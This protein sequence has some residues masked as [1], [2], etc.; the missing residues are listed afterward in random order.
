MKPSELT[1]EIFKKLV[2]KDLCDSLKYDEEKAS[3][4]MEEN[5]DVI[6][7]GFRSA[8]DEKYFCNTHKMNEEDLA[9]FKRGD[10]IN[11]AISNT[12]YCLFMLE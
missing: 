10:Y 12:S 8:T 3:R 7:D 1:F 5:L 4:L 9:R 11:N 2:L 6:E